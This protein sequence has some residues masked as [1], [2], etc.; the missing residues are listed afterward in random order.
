VLM[1]G[2]FG[3]STDI[4]ELQECFVFDSSSVD[5]VKR[6]NI[7]PSNSVLT[8]GA[9]GPRTAEYMR[10]GLIPSWSKPNNTA[11]PHAH[12]RTLA[13]NARAETL[14]T[15]GMFRGPFKSKRCIVLSDGFYEWRKNE[16][17]TT[18]PLRIGMSDWKPFGMAGLWDAW[19]GP[20][21]VIHSCTI[22]TTTPNDLTVTVHGR[23]PVILPFESHEEW[24]SSS[25]HD[26]DA[27]SRLLTA[28]PANAMAMYEISPAI[29]AVKN[30]TPGLLQPLT[31]S[32]LL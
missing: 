21:G 20:N 4:E 26:T 3:I 15:N 1:C 28:Y 9:Q 12:K 32:K 31:Q 18:T 13:I 16:N 30:D 25:Q 24:L 23:M 10:W 11:A 2:R 22:I 27:L 6:Y 5:Y 29:G 19:E 17:A 8:Y 7:A 14:A